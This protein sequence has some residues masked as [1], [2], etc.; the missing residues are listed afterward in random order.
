M[1]NMHNWHRLPDSAS[2]C[3]MMTN[4]HRRRHRMT[5]TREA[6]GAPFSPNPVS[7]S[8]EIRLAYIIHN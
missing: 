5:K 2:A 7:A 1:H 3:I 6:L 8:D 4:L